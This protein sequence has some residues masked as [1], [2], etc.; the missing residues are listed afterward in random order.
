MAVADG[1]WSWVAATLRGRLSK[2]Q[3]AP[4]RW[5]RT[6]VRAL[7]GLGFSCQLSSTFKR[8]LANAPHLTARLSHQQPWIERIRSICGLTLALQR[9]G[10]FLAS[11]PPL[12]SCATW[13]HPLNLLFQQSKLTEAQ[14]RAN[15][16]QVDLRS[17]QYLVVQDTVPRS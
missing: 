3:G 17:S 1:F 8:A 12:L 4:R 14:A 11:V 9:G 16:G 2:R 7:L 15:S 10:R 5:R 6:G 13:T